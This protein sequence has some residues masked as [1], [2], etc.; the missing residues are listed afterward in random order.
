MDNKWNEHLVGK[1]EKLNSTKDSIE[2]TCYSIYF[3]KIS[4]FSQGRDI[5]SFF[6][7]GKVI[8]T[9]MGIA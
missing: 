9:Y 8:F 1:L 6:F 3:T 7:Q 4:L 5:F 2:G